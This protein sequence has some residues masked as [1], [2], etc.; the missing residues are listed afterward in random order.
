MQ[1]QGVKDNSTGAPRVDLSV[2][3]VVGQFKRGRI[4]RMFAV[5][6]ESIRARLGYS[7]DNPDYQVVQDALDL[8]VPQVWV[9]RIRGAISPP[10]VQGG[11]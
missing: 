2:A 8:G 3:V 1:Y 10:P 6:K 5:T 7:P 4:D 9:R 11:V